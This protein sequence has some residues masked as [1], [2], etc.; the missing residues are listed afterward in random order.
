MPTSRADRGARIERDEQTRA[1]IALQ[2]EPIYA[3]AFSPDGRFVVSGVATGLPASGRRQAVWKWRKQTTEIKRPVWAVAFS[4]DGRF[5]VSGGDDGTARVWE[6]ASGV[7]WLKRHTERSSGSRFQ[8]G[9]ALRD[10]RRRGRDRP[11]LGGG[12]RDGDRRT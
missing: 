6:A 7:K 2:Q 10:Q 12:E 11:C 4:P 9:W 8:P 1:W 5:V 3:V